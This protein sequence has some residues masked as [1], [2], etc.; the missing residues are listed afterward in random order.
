MNLFNKCVNSDF[1]L[2]QNAGIQIENR[3]YSIEELKIIENKI[4]DFIISS[5]K[6]EIPRLMNKYNNIFEF[7]SDY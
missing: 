5:S 2:L 6:I 1:V 4:T 7:L 3:D